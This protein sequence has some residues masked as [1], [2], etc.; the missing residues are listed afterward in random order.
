MKKTR[1]LGCEK[2][3]LSGCL[4]GGE[5]KVVT[6]GLSELWSHVDIYIYCIYIYVL[7][8]P[9]PSNSDKIHYAFSRE[10]L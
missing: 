10:P 8:W 5:V 2:M 7:V 6:L 9:L 1:S 4:G 3:D